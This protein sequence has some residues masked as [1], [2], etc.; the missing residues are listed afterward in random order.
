MSE[1][2]KPEDELPP[3]FELPPGCYLDMQ[4]D[5][6]WTEKELE[7]LRNC[8]KDAEPK[9]PEASQSDPET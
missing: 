8:R 9:E 2:N 7:A 6:D 5:E 3:D 4:L 1:N